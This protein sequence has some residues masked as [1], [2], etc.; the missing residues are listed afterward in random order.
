MLLVDMVVALLN[1][2]DDC[3]TVRRKQHQ[4]LTL[5]LVAYLESK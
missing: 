4:Q 1:G 3:S 5:P 2:L